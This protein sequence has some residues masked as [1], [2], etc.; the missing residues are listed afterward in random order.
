MPTLCTLSS[1]RNSRDHTRSPQIQSRCPEMGC[2]VPHGLFCSKY[3]PK[4]SSSSDSRCPAPRCS[5]RSPSSASSLWRSSPKLNH[6][7]SRPPSC[8]RLPFCQPACRV[9]CWPSV[10][11]LAASRPWQ[12]LTGS[13][14]SPHVRRRRIQLGG[15]DFHRARPIRICLGWCRDGAEARRARASGEAAAAAM[16]IVSHRSQS[17]RAP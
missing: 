8:R 2:S 5:S 6:L 9:R 10:A 13:S 7:P 16:T 1:A 4:L 3:R 15:P 17:P 12:A 14:S 11:G